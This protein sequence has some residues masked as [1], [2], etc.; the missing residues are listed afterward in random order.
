MKEY[1]VAMWFA[2]TCLRLW[3][4][5]WWLVPFAE[6]AGTPSARVSACTLRGA[7]SVVMHWRVASWGN[8]VGWLLLVIDGLKVLQQWAQHWALQLWR[9][10]GSDLNYVDNQEGFTRAQLWEPFYSY[11]MGCMQRSF[12]PDVMRYSNTFCVRG[13]EYLWQRDILPMD[14]TQEQVI[15]T[16]IIT[17]STSIKA[18]EKGSTRPRPLVLLRLAS[19]DALHPDVI[20]CSDVARRWGKV[21]GW[22]CTLQLLDDTW[23]CLLYTSDAADE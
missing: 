16:F 17:I 10:D 21:F 3:R 7:H 11:W 5:H 19:E 8:P 15:W 22:P 9:L 23:H 4:M 18:F 20:I 6:F 2:P 14:H 1:L 13:W 12:A